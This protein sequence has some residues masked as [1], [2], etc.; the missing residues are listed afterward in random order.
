MDKKVLNNLIDKIKLGD[1]N[2]FAEFCELTNKGVFLFVYSFVK[3]KET[4][5][6][7]TQETYIKVRRNILAYHSNTNST[8][9]LLQIA[10]NL[11]LD[12]LKKYKKA[13]HHWY[14]WNWNCWRWNRRWLWILKTN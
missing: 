6:D 12:Y 8:A 14:F 3:Q 11:A 2:S 13:N 9:W 1:E 10:K 4:A 7:L 5:E